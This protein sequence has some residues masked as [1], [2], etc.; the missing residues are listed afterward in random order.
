MMRMTWLISAVLALGCAPSA[1]T[2]PPA[3]QPLVVIT[4]PNQRDAATGKWVRVEGAVSDTKMP[5][6][7]G[8]DIDE[9]S[10]PIPGSSA[11]RVRDIRGQRAWAEGILVRHVVRPEDVNNSFANRGAGTFF[12][13]RDPRTGKTAIAHPVSDRK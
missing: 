1:T 7:A 6:I 10:D 9:P 13:L 3:T 12:E 2:R 11:R 4:D 5:Q 8:V